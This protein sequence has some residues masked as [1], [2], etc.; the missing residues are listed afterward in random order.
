MLT[1]EKAQTTKLSFAGIRNAPYKT[2]DTLIP[3][4]A[5]TAVNYTAANEV[6]EP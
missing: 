6:N 2:E 1:C 4:G 5:M 3:D